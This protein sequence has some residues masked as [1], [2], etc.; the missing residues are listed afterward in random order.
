MGKLEKVG[1]WKMAATVG[2]IFIILLA[3]LGIFPQMEIAYAAGALI[4]AGGGAGDIR[5]TH[6]SQPL[7]FAPPFHYNETRTEIPPVRKAKAHERRR[8]AVRLSSR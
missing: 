8:A 5:N 7:G 4:L 6:P 1:N 3:I 2:L